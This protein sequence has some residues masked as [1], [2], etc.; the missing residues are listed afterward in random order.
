MPV[1]KL[2][3]ASWCHAVVSVSNVGCVM[4]VG[5]CDNLS[6]K[7][8][9][10]ILVVRQ[11]TRV[12]LC[13]A[14]PVANT[15]WK[16]IV[17]NSSLTS[18]E[19]L[20]R[21]TTTAVRAGALAVGIL[22]M[23]ASTAPA[24][25]V[26]SGD[27]VSFDFS[28]LQNGVNYL[29]FG[30]HLIFTPPDVMQLGDNFRARVFENNDVLLFT[31]TYNAGPT[32]FNDFGFITFTSGFNT[33]YVVLDQFTGSFNLGAVEVFG[34]IGDNEFTELLPARFEVG[35]AEVPVPPAAA[36]FPAGLALLGL[37][38]RRRPRKPRLSRGR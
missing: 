18:I 1:G 22:F 15:L 24:V 31:N 38:T 16:A 21:K 11:A 34:K 28:A 29:D 19:N 30:V 2:F 26:T 13:D 37:L 32:P 27:A 33:K 14:T 36:L 6:S 35:V 12:K 10:F 5:N 20:F 3:A 8:E 9:S 4:R 17:K 7:A 23:G 25:P